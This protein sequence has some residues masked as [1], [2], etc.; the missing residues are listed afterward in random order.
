MPT[1]RP[2]LV[3]AIEAL[4]NVRHVFRG[5][6]NAVIFH[7]GR[8]SI[9]LPGDGQI[10]ND[11]GRGILQRIVEQREEEPPQQTRRALPAIVAFTPCLKRPESGCRGHPP[12]HAVPERRR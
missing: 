5:N 10:H 8:D 2:R 4:E 1:I 7:G 12:D 11:A 3:C 9:A 6:T